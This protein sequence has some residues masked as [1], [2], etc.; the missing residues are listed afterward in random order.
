[1]FDRPSVLAKISNISVQNYAE[2]SLT[3]TVQNDNVQN[4]AEAI[5]KMEPAR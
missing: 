2:A 5:K 4:D 3:Q 1:M